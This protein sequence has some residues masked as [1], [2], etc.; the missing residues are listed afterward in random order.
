MIPIGLTYR[1]L[2]NAKQR[3]GLNINSLKQRNLLDLV[4]VEEFLGF[5]VTR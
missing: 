3:F 1:R 2:I 4:N 5:M